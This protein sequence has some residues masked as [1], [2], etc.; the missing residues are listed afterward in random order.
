M[1]IQSATHAQPAPPVLHAGLAQRH[2][3]YFCGRVQGV[4]FRYTARNISM[5]HDVRGYVRN[6]PD[7][8]VELVL[9]GCQ[10]ELSRVTDEI[11]RKMNA[12]VRGV[13]RQESPATGE[14][15]QFSI[16]H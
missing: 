9:E 12:F 5:Q 14:F 6:L 3:I 15:D 16:R 10:D 1:Q 8:R 2:T 13:T 11:L 4:G 7:G